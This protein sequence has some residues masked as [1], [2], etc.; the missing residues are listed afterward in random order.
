LSTRQAAKLI[1]LCGEKEA[2]LLVELVAAQPHAE[3]D[4]VA[5]FNGQVMMHGTLR[6]RPDLLV[7]R[8]SCG[9]SRRG[10]LDGEAAARRA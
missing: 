7:D 1:E 4:V 3:E 8:R 2:C 9:F 6:V 10:R 5:V